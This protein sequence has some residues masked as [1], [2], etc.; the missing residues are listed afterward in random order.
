MGEI[1]QPEPTNSGLAW[2]EAQ[3]RQ[4]AEW[5]QQGISIGEIANRMGRTSGAIRSQAVRMAPADLGLGAGEVIGWLRVQLRHGHDWRKTLE[6]RSMRPSRNGER[7][8]GQETEQLV[9]ELRG[10]ASW[11][12]IA[13]A[14]ERTKGAIIAQAARMLVLT[15]KTVE[16]SRSRRAEQLRLELREQADYDWRRA[17]LVDQASGRSPSWVFIVVG[18][19]PDGAWH[20]R[21]AATEAAAARIRSEAGVP[22]GTEWETFER[23]VLPDYSV[24]SEDEREVSP[25]DA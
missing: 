23:P 1:E 22:A 5:L 8:G 9:E 21:A 6:E 18:A 24:S 11:Q 15:E 16:W 10:E 20:V 2:D 4:L 25:L 17:L 14:H 3:N 7:W 13:N 12:A 19:S